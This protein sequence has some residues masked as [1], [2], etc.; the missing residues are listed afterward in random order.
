MK[1]LPKDIQERFPHAHVVKDRDEAVKVLMEA[2]ELDDLI[3][4][5]APPHV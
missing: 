4:P 5:M 1:A 2:G 3:H